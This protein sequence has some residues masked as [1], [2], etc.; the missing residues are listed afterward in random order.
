VIV[1]IARFDQ[2]LHPGIETGDARTPRNRGFIAIR[3]GLKASRNTPAMRI[4]NRRALRQPAL[5]ITPPENLL[6][7]FIGNLGAMRS[8]GS[9]HNLLL[10]DQAVADIGG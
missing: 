5:P 7:E 1:Q 8:N 3:W 9:G 4:P 10:G 6:D 2:L